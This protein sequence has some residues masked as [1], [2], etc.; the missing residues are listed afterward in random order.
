[1]NISFIFIL[2]Y[3]YIPY[4]NLYIL[5]YMFMSLSPSPYVHISVPESHLSVYLCVLNLPL[6]CREPRVAPWCVLPEPMAT[7]GWSQIYSHFQ[8]LPSFLRH[9]RLLSTSLTTTL[10]HSPESRASSAPSKEGK[11][12]NKKI[13]YIFWKAFSLPLPLLLQS[14]QQ[15]WQ[16]KPA[17]VVC[18]HRTKILLCRYLLSL[19]SLTS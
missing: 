18:P 7:N 1:M 17:I 11:I 6:L 9:L 5:M 8:F 19:V 13:P 10:F 12:N 14:N 16:G 2:W 3:I 15:Q 4:I